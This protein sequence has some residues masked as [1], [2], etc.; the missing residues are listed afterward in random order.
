M[1]ELAMKNF[2]LQV[3]FLKN[4]EYDMNQMIKAFKA[5]TE[6]RFDYENQEGAKELQP[7]NLKSKSKL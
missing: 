7:E 6:K 4:R 3:D 2:I 5:Q 1:E